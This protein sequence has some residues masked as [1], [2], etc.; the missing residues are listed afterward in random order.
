MSQRYFSHLGN[1]NNPSNKLQKEALDFMKMRSNRIVEDPVKF[2]AH[3]KENIQALNERFPRCKPMRVDRWESTGSSIC[4][5][6]G[7][8][9]TLGLY[10]YPIKEVGE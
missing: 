5:G 4:L 6:L 9:Y 8:N 1:S 7:I 3:I 2:I 10:L